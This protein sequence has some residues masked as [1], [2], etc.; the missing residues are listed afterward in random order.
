M[1]VTKLTLTILAFVG[2]PPMECAAAT[3]ATGGVIVGD[4]TTSLAK[5]A[6]MNE[7][8]CVNFSQL[9]S[10]TNKGLHDA[11]VLGLADNFWLPK[12]ASVYGVHSAIHDLVKRFAGNSLF[13]ETA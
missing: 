10:I 2:T 4:Q 12:F 9:T 1:V 7:C 5:A 8:K 13:G 11:A 3:F 6:K